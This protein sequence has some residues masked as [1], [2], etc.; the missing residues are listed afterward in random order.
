[1][2]SVSWSIELSED[3]IFTIW[4]NRA[5]LHFFGNLKILLFPIFIGFEELKKKTYNRL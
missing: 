2:A 4:L 1:M 3:F 5:A